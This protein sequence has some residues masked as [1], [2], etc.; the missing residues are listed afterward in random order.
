MQHILGTTEFYGLEFLS[1]ARALIPRPDSEIVVETALERISRD[2]PAF[3]ADLGTGS[4][5]LLA[6]L[7]ANRPLARGKG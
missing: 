4:G 3:I 5:C 6:V 1:D 2:Q 7:L